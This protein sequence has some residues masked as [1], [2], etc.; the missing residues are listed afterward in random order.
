[1]SMLSLGNTVLLVSS[2]V[3]NLVSNAKLTKVG[4]EMLIFP[5][6]IRLY[7]DNL[8]IEPSFNKGLKFQEKFEDVRFMTQQIDLSEFT[9]IM[10][11]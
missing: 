11:E 10:N 8:L 1:M 2:G 5:T 6:P 4:V 7:G 9:I 3:G